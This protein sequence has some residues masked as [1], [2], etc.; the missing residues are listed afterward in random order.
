MSKRLI[1]SNDS[2]EWTLKSRPKTVIK[3]GKKVHLKTQRA[4]IFT[5]VCKNGGLWCLV[6]Q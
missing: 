6:L 4:D 2:R 5:I 3:R 1:I